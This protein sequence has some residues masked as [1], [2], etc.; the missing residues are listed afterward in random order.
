MQVQADH[1]TETMRSVMSSC[2]CR[3]LNYW[4]VCTAL[5]AAASNHSSY[6]DVLWCM[7]G[8]IEL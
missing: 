2:I 4:Y 3:V 6:S 1:R 5:L 8:Y 7:I